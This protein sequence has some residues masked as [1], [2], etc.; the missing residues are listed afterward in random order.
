MQ[1]TGALGESAAGA[2]M[3]LLVGFLVGLS[4]TPV[5]GSVIAAL[6][7][8]LGAFLGL[9]DKLT[10]T[11]EQRDGKPWRVAAFGVACALGVALG[12]TVRANN[13]LVSSPKARVA[14]WTDA[15]FS[16]DRARELVTYAEFGLRPSNA[17]A[18]DDKRG[19]GAKSGVLFGASEADCAQL[20]RAGY[21]TDADRHS[22]FTQFGGQWKMLADSVASLPAQ[23]RAD[24]LEAA[25]QLACAP[26]GK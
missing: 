9:T 26:Q 6:T 19:V 18:E 24:A 2:A 4:I 7:A 11:S 21:G 20:R 16:G 13:L 5:V 15:G 25:W 17:T 1:K 3:G 12:I 22:A 10:A 8:L 23:A 14:A